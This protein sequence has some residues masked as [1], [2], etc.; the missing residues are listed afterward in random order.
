MPL[1]S[2]TLVIRTVHPLI[3]F[4]LYNEPYVNKPLTKHCVAFHCFLINV[5]VFLLLLCFKGVTSV[6]VIVQLSI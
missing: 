3:N 2:L 6:V 5:N 1:C 4:M